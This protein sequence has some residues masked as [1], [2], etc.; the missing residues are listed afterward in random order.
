M[1]TMRRSSRSGHRDATAQSE[2][3]SG[4]R[5]AF[6]ILVGF[7]I[8]CALGGGASRPDVLSL[9][10]LRPAA[11][12]C[13]AALLL[14]PGEWRLRR[15]RM[16]L[17]LLGALALVIA[18]QLVPLPSALWLSLPGR[19][20]FAEAAAAA[21]MAQ[22][23]R[24]LSLTPDETWNSVLALLPALVVLLA[25]ARLDEQRR[26]NLLPWIIGLTGLSAV[27]ALIQLGTGRGSL[28]YLYR[29]THEGAAV[30][31]FANRNHQAALLA[32][33]FP[34]LRLWTLQPVSSPNLQFVR[35][36]AAAAIAMFLVP[37][38]LVTGSRA[39][40]ALGL[41]GMVLTLLLFRGTGELRLPARWQRWR[42]AIR[43]LP[44]VA[45][46]AVG[47]AAAL[48][49][50]AE[51][52][53]RLFSLTSVEEQRFSYTPLTLRIARDF[54]PFGS[55]FG[56]FDPVFRIYEPA[57]Q[58]RPNYFNRA[59][60]DLIELG[61]TGGLPA[62][63][64]L[65]VFLLWAARLGATASLPLRTRSESLLFARA[66]GVMMLILLMASL[67]DYPLRTPL[68]T[69]LFALACG[70]LCHRPGRARIG[71]SAD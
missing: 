7:L 33:T 27:L 40:L 67:V 23:W 12:L 14:L 70:W 17:I 58:L 37:L 2:L 6:A 19:E 35:N 59:H 39:G 29:V 68:M 18:V 4:G 13:L 50:R 61:L 38:I 71:S 5:I 60:N 45:L 56:S 62:L 1:V 53:Q 21:G 30:G 22:P 20:R 15:F 52:V 11:V 36:C 64:V 44:W 65:A 26:K 51:A 31:L 10:Y 24:P 57:D 66:G 9:L 42:R 28:V 47:A 46:I 54:F 16:P 8:L 48:L 49:G 55:G 3:R 32:M 25:L 34:L 43:L 63:L 69:A 41:A